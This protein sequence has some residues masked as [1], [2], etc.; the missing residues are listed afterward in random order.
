MSATRPMAGR[1]SAGVSPHGHQSSSPACRS[2]CSAWV[3]RLVIAIALTGISPCSSSRPGGATAHRGGGNERPT[4][5]IAGA[6]TAIRGPRSARA[7][8]SSVGDVFNSQWLGQGRLH[9]A[10]GSRGYGLRGTALRRQGVGRVVLGVTSLRFII[11]G[12]LVAKFGLGHGLSS[13]TLLLVNVIAVRGRGRDALPSPR[14]LTIREAQWRLWTRPRH[15][16]VFMALTPA[17]G[18]AE[19]QPCCSRR[20]CRSGPAGRVFGFQQSVEMGSGPGVGLPHRPDRAVL[21]D[22]YMR[23]DDGQDRWAW[24]LGR[25]DTRALPWSS[26]SRASS[27]SSPCCSP[28]CPGPTA[29]SRR[30]TYRQATS[31]VTKVRVP[32]P[33]TTQLDADATA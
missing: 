14:P 21:A 3:G 26:S 2:V 15:P 7:D 8:P 23:T 9:G 31:L 28:S 6:M 33:M 19:Q 17:A 12:G 1:H 10:H 27:C 20:S 18:A 25:G 13:R 32:A 30:P 24:L 5:D 4:F 29:S 11:G 16:L 22:P